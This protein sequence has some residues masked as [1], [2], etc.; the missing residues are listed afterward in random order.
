[1]ARAGIL[2]DAVAIIVIVTVISIL[3]PLLLP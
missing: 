3:A 1:M 2:L